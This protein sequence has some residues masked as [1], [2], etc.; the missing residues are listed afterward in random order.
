M[1]VPICHYCLYV[2]DIGATHKRETSEARNSS[3]D[4]SE[5]RPVS[6][7]QL[8]DADSTLIGARLEKVAKSLQES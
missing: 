5:I 3:V 6:F 4:G 1:Q 7:S 8:W 2:G